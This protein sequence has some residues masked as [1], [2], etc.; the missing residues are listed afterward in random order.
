[1]D[2]RLGISTVWDGWV[3]WAAY[4]K[5]LIGAQDVLCGFCGLVIR[6]R[7]TWIYG[8]RLGWAVLLIFRRNKTCTDRPCHLIMGWPV[9]A[10]STC[11]YLKLDFFLAASSCLSL[12]SWSCGTYGTVGPLVANIRLGCTV[13]VFNVHL[14]CT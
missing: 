9:F 11:S 10:V 14:E 12:Y 2:G 8:L 6:R 1:M 13:L 3:G 7:K 4:K 5:G